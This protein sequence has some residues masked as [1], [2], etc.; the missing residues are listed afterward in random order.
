MTAR[1]RTVSGTWPLVRDACLLEP[2]NKDVTVGEL[3]E[4]QRVV[5]VAGRLPIA[6]IM[7][8]GDWLSGG[9]SARAERHKRISYLTTSSRLEV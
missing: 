6:G 5:R 1:S 3:V 8:M 4:G 2:L 7:L 9:P